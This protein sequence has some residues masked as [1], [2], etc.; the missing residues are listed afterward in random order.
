MRTAMIYVVLLSSVTVARAQDKEGPALVEKAVKAHGGKENILK[1]RVATVKF[2]LKGT[3]PGLPLGGATDITVEETYQLP[4]QIK[5][6]ITGKQGPLPIKLAWAIDGDKVWIQDSDGEVK[7]QKWD[8]DNENSFR[9]YLVMEQLARLSPDE[10]AMTALGESD[11]K[12]HKVL[13]VRVRSDKLRYD[14]D[15]FF[16]KATGLLRAMKSKNTHPISKK[17]IL[18]ESVFTDYKE[19]DGVKLF[20]TQVMAMDGKQAAEIR[21]SEVRFFKKLDGS[22]FAQPAK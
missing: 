16:D 6:V 20:G 5:K 1:L 2:T 9:A 3:R 18:G 10:Y 7:V 12:G 11:V 4:R 19:V 8:Q 13:G 22:V 15:L 17:E 14:A 21:V